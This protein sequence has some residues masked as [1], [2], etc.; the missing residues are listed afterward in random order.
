M[1]GR[2]CRVEPIDI[3]RHVDELH[4]AFSAAS[5]AH[6]WTYLATEFLDASA[7]R[8]WLVKMRQGN[9]PMPHAIVD[10]RSGKAVGIAC[11]M[12]IDP[13]NGLIEVGHINY[14]PCLQR[15]PAGTE[16]MFLMMRRVFDELGYRRY[17]WKCDNLNKPSRVA[18]ER[19]GFQF[20]G[21]FRQAIVCK[22]RNRDTAWYA[23]I[24][25]DWPRLRSAFERWL[26]PT[27]FNEAGHQRRKLSSLRSS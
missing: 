12:R 22:G 2:F 4:E 19:L 14:A 21:I 6:N 11:Y 18:A 23:I 17:E 5:D 24:D 27:N 26:D 1:T 8:A 13:D 10:L 9:D 15:T 7:Y 25:K 20:E 3:E 16:A